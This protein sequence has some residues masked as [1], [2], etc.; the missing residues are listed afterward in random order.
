ME[1]ARLKNGIY[2]SQ[3]KY[4]LDLLTKTSMLAY[5]S[6]VK[7]TKVGNKNEELG[8]PVN[9]NKYTRLVGKLIHLS[10]TRPTIVFVVN[11]VSQ[12]IH[13]PKEAY[14]ETV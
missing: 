12:H 2:V 3:R 10:H 4:I 11:V 6:S 1:V 14:L 7:P 5:K 9:K 13:S 8:K